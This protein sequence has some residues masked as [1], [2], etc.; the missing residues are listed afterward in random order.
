MCHNGMIMPSFT[1]AGNWGRKKNP[2]GQWETL[3]GDI[4]ECLWNDSGCS[5]KNKWRGQKTQAR[6]SAGKLV[7]RD[8]GLT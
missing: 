7:R 2:K 5:K 4:R 1:M 8:D 3:K 6:R